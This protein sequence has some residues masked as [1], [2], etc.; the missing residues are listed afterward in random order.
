MQ[1]RQ[2]DAINHDL[3]RANRFRSL[4]PGCAACGHVIVLIHAVAA[5]TQAADKRAINIE[6]L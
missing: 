4:E 2:A 5:D 1:K 3:V 6:R